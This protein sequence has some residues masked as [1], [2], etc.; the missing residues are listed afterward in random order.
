MSNNKCA[1]CK[2]TE[3]NPIHESSLFCIR[4]PPTPQLIHV[5]RN[6]ETGAIIGT[7]QL[8]IFPIVRLETSCGEFF[9]KDGMSN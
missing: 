9:P 8:A 5:N 3:K 1:N 6:N 7:E 2:W 4:F